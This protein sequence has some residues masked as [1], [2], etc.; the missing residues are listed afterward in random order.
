MRIEGSQISPEITKHFERLGITYGHHELS[1]HNLE[2]CKKFYDGSIPLPMENIIRYVEFP[3]GAVYSAQLT[4]HDGEGSRRRKVSPV[5]IETQE[6]TAGAEYISLMMVEV[7]QEV[8]VISCKDDRPEDP[9]LCFLEHT[10]VGDKDSCKVRMSEFFNTLELES[11]VLQPERSI[12]QVPDEEVVRCI[13]ES[14]ITDEFM[15]ALSPGD[16]RV[17]VDVCVTDLLP[18]LYDIEENPVDHPVMDL[19]ICEDAEKLTGNDLRLFL[20]E[21]LVNSQ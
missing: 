17:G 16:T 10:E 4:E 8:I 9:Y 7:T 11:V 20:I 19:L 5:A 13:E 2:W 1:E 18:V 14:G 12:S 3:R 15:L 21:G 6:E